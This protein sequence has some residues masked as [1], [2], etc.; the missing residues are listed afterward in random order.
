MPAARTSLYPCR[1]DWP[2]RSPVSR[3]FS[4]AGRGGPVH[5][6]NFCVVRT[7]AFR[8]EVP[9]LA[10]PFAGTAIAESALPTKIRRPTA[11]TADAGDDPVFALL[12]MRSF[13]LL[14]EDAAPGR[15]EWLPFA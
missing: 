2:A 15:R 4:P 9:S 8:G 6:G 3:C 14:R 10:C 13:S 12:S 11:P 5:S 7:L 1:N